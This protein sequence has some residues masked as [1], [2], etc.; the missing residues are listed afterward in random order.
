M[1]RAPEP[2]S[3]HP[4]THLSV[5]SLLFF[6]P[7][8]TPWSSAQVPTTIPSRVARAPVGKA[9]FAA[10]LLSQGASCLRKCGAKSP[11]GKPDSS[12]PG[13]IEWNPDVYSF[14]F[15]SPS[16]QTDARSMSPLPL[17]HI[18]THRYVHIADWYG[19]FCSLAGVNTSDPAAEAANLPPVDSLDMWPL[20]SGNERPICTPRP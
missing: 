1:Q 5:Y 3:F 12:L 13:I 17:S 15:P 4:L 20:L 8:L 14:F 2:Y 6:S 18:H 9:A 7:A 10:L 19:T 16:S 11:M